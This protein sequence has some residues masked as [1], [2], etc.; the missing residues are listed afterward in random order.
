[1][2]SN[3]QEHTTKRNFL[4]MGVRKVLA[5]GVLA[6]SAVAARTKRAVAQSDCNADDPPCPMCFLKG[7]KI[8]TVL[9]ERKVEDLAVGDLLPTVFGGFKRGF[10]SAPVS[11]SGQR[12]SGRQGFL[13]E[14][15]ETLVCKKIASRAIGCVL[16]GLV[17]LSTPVRA[18]AECPQMPPVMRFDADPFYSDARGSIVDE[19]KLRRLQ[20]NLRPVRNFLY[21]VGMRADQ[22]LEHGN[23]NAFSCAAALMREW[24][25][26]GA[27]TEPSKTNEEAYDRILMVFA[28]SGI[29]QKLKATNPSY[30]AGPADEWLVRLAARSINDFPRFHPPIGNMHDWLAATAASV[31]LTTN[32]NMLRTYASRALSQGLSEVDNSG[33]LLQE[34][35]RGAQALVYHAYAFTALAFAEFYLSGC[36]SV[37]CGDPALVRLYHRVVDGVV[38]PKVFVARTNV[39]QNDLP[40]NLRVALCEFADPSKPRPLLQQCEDLNHVDY[41]LGGDM[42]ALFSRAAP[43]LLN[44]NSR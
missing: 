29:Q 43:R 34:S 12:G 14:D 8:Q 2:N 4:A 30:G 13:Q 11:A 6:A 42:H 44:N 7:T 31:A 20:E 33:W 9:G 21:Q 27:L 1:M 38:D 28:L 17:A 41:N 35:E 37:S 23:D 25:R 24:A 5:I 15:G 19:A 16:F 10:A 36:L 39:K 18:D 40:A 32:D 22:A 3:E 26:A